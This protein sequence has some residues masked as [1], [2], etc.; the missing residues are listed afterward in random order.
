MGTI[1]GAGPRAGGPLLRPH[2]YSGC[3]ISRVLCEKWGLFAAIDSS[4]FDGGG[5][6]RLN[7]SSANSCQTVRLPHA[8]E[9]WATRQS[10]FKN[11]LTGSKF[12]LLSPHFPKVQQQIHM[13]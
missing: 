9:R 6:V 2:K 12:L 8:P 3:P 4:V 11:V 1:L 10:N 7:V 13:Q 5:S